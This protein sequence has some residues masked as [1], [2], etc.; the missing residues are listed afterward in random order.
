MNNQYKFKNE[1]IAESETLTINLNLNE[2]HISFEI[3]GRIID[4]FL[5][6]NSIV[7]SLNQIKTTI[8]TIKGLDLTPV[9]LHQIIKSLILDYS[10]NFTKSKMRTINLQKNIFKDELLRCT[11]DSIMELRN[12]LYAHIGDKKSLYQN[13]MISAYRTENGE[14]LYLSD[15]TLKQIHKEKKYIQ[16]VSNLT[17]YLLEATINKRQ[18]IYEEIAD[19]IKHIDINLYSKNTFLFKDIKFIKKGII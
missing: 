4:Q 13:V 17:E 19:M 8:N 15:I 7:E 18:R 1:F 16:Q 3:Q 6:Y 14:L 5:S 10:I 11:H 12:N 9:V 2:P